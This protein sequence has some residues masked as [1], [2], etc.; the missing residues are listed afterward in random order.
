MPEQFRFTW[1]HTRARLFGSRSDDR[2]D[3]ARALDAHAGLI[4][5][6]AARV[7]GNLADAEDVAQDIAERLLKSPPTAVRS[8]AAYLK[9]MAINRAVDQL[10]RR[11]HWADV[12]PTGVGGDPEA[13]FYDAQRADILRR[14]IAR[15][16]ERDGR[17]FALYYLGDLSHAEVAAQVNMT[18][19]AVAVALHRLRARLAADVRASLGLAEGELV[20]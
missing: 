8:W 10:R 16:S 6:S 17:I 7:L 3:L 15:L 20:K 9:A 5:S 14:A 4:I 13:A 18:E 12:D 2:V 1:A 19:N 11:K